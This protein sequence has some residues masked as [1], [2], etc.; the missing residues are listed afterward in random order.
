MIFIF[1]LFY[2]I[3]ECRLVSWLIVKLGRYTFSHCE[4]ASVHLRSADCIGVVSWDTTPAEVASY[5][6]RQ[7]ALEIDT[8]HLVDTGHRI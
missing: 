2:F 7:G 4:S 1:I 6:H 3:Y 5:R 8:V